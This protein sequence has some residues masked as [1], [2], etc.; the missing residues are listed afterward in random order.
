MIDKHS[1]VRENIGKMLTFCGTKI[2][3]LMFGHAN[4]GWLGAVVTA[5][6]PR[7]LQGSLLSVNPQN[8]LCTVLDAHWFRL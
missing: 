2:Y 8:S 7:V 1:S 3:V 6:V 4:T 5:S